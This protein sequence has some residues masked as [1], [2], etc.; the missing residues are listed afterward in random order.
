MINYART[1]NSTTGRR[2]EACSRDAK[3]SRRRPLGAAAL[4]TD[5]PAAWA[6]DHAIPGVRGMDHVGITVPDIAE[7]RTLVRRCHRLPDAAAL[8][9]VQRPDGHVHA[10][11]ARGGSARGDPR[12]Q[13]A[14]LRDGLEH[15]AV[16]VHLARPGHEAGAEL[17]LQRPPPRVLRRGHRR[18]CRLHGVQ[19]RAQ[20]ARAVPR[21]RRAG[22]RAVDQL[23]PGALRDLRRAD[24][25]SRRHGLR[26]DR[27]AQAVERSRHRRQ[28]HRPRNPRAA[29]PRPRRHHRARHQARPHVAARRTWAARPRCASARSPIRRA[30]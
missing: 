7:A 23:L 28:G 5:V 1:G 30:R 27:Q 13:R 9:A 6:H 21:D 18:R 12:D 15:R 25:L 20:A 14:A 11:P 4:A 2:R 29:R 19:G 22:R 3:L 8:R 17:R 10:G 16:R 26:G 24:L